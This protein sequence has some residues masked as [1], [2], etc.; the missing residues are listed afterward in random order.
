MF[1]NQLYTP[2]LHSRVNPYLKITLDNY[3]RDDVWYKIADRCEKNKGD[4]MPSK[5]EA[6]E[7]I[8]LQI[9]WLRANQ[10]N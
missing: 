3:I 8:K 2:H 6:K 4:E 9:Q 1:K 7:R 5:E 10:Q